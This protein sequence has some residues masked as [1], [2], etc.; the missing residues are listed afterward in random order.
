MAFHATNIQEIVA[1]NR[2]SVPGRA[3]RPR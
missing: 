3:F 1:T 2:Q